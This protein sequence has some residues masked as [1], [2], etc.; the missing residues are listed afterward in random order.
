MVVVAI[1]SSNIPR[2]LLTDANGVLQTFIPGINI[3]TSG[4]VAVGVASTNVLA[5]NANRR[6][7]VFVNDSA[8][9]IYLFFGTPA[10]LN[11]GIRLN[12]LG[13][14]YEINQTCLYTGQVTAIATAV[15]SN[16]T[17]TEG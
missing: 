5:A 14:A 7:A 9:I 1:D 4:N 16:L 8:A 13:G 17:V 11:Q 15:G 10:V 6:F 2:F 3:A 12:A